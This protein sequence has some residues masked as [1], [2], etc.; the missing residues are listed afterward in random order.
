M[1]ES[2]VNPVSEIVEEQ[3]PIPLP[4]VVEASP[5]S[6][7]KTIQVLTDCERFELRPVFE[8]SVFYHEVYVK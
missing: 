8:E 6:R 5:L 7:S 3:F 4:D 2:A 1:G